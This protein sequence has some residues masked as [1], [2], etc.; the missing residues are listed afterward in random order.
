M[1]IDLKLHKILEGHRAA[2]YALG[3]NSA[4]QLLSAG[5]EGWV[6][7]WDYQHTDDGQVLAQV[8]ANIFALSTLAQDEELVLGDMYGQVYWLNLPQKTTLHR[9]QAHQK[10]VFALLRQN[11]Q[12]YSLGGDG[13]LGLWD[14][15]KRRLRQSL[16]L[17]AQSLRCLV[18][19]PQ[20]D[21]LIIGGSDGCIRVLDAQTWALRQVLPQA[22]EPSVF[23][24][25]LSPDG[26]W[27]WSGGRD[28]R[29]QRWER[30]AQGLWQLEQR[31]PAHWFTLNA[32]CW[33][34]G[35]EILFTASR[36]KSLK[37]W[38]ARDFR[39][40]KVLDR[41]KFPQAHT[42]SVNALYCSPC[43]R[44]LCSAGDDRRILVWAIEV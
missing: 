4:G 19:D 12:V 34:P 16:Q 23:C 39:L 9:W 17:S 32:L 21:S 31:S 33:H 11:N 14:V 41:S 13:V 35:G 2:I 25:S 22:H 30:D 40:L 28:A 7:A 8:E 10:G 27:L 18:F 3:A 38:S 36:D 26:Q 37:V 15:D 43:G 24:L 42:H 20:T 44:Y 1:K 6:V 29:L 5:G